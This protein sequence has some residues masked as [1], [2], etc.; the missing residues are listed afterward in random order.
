[1]QK[2]AHA[3]GNSNELD[4]KTIGKEME[5]LL[6]KKCGENRPKCRLTVWD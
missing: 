1:M 4:L 5:K 2:D 3:S 6:N